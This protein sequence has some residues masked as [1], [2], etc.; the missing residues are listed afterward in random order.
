MSVLILPN[1]LNQQPQQATP[2][3]ASLLTGPAR[4][5]VVWAPSFGLVDAFGAAV[6]VTGTMTPGINQQGI[7][8]NNTAVSNNFSV[9]VPATSNN[10]CMMVVGRVTNSMTATHNMVTCA[11]FNWQVNTSF[12]F[13]MNNSYYGTFPSADNGFA[14]GK[15]FFWISGKGP[16]GEYM[17]SINGVPIGLGGYTDG[18]TKAQTIA[19]GVWKFGGSQ[20]ATNPPGFE[21]N[22][23]SVF[24]NL[25]V[26]QLAEIVGNNP[27][28]IF[29]APQRRIWVS[30]AGGP[31][32]Y[33]YSASGGLVVSGTGP[34]VKGAIKTPTGGLTLLGTASPTRGVTRT[35]TGGLTFSGAAT[36]L[37]SLVRA[38]TG[39][40]L[41]SGAASLSFFSA[42]Q[43]LTVVATG[44][45]LIRG[46][47]AMLRTV[48][49]AATGGIIF[50]GSAS[51]VFTPDPNASTKHNFKRGRRPRTRPNY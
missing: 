40:I 45:L 38:A 20:D 44:G 35:T 7:G 4:P 3:N 41:F 36:P 33:S 5:S 31:Q 15:P 49:K 48:V 12:R 19:A 47:A 10:F 25:N 21:I 46:T 32:T 29:K 22:L 42:V 23:F 37:R 6:S 9:S 26:L 39:G 50:G 8:F 18:T 34:T 17:H 1:R 43:S 2:Y 11:T 30:S 28:Q 14:V 51:T 24:P 27:W 16:N 13:L